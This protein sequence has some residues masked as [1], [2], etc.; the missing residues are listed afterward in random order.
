M[1]QNPQGRVGTGQRGERGKDA[2]RDAPKRTKP[3][4]EIEKTNIENGN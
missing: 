4:L 3:P 2:L 1:P